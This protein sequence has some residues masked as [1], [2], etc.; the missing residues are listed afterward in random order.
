[1][2]MEHFVNVE[3]N[4]DGGDI[5]LGMNKVAFKF[6]AIDNFTRYIFPIIL[7][8]E[9]IDWKIIPNEKNQIIGLA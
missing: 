4:S 7:A 2:V 8:L 6:K 3:L 1:M 9:I 5:S